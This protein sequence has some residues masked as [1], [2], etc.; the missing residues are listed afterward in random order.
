MRACLCVLSVY[1]GVR[2]GGAGSGRG[3]VAMLALLC[4][5]VLGLGGLDRFGVHRRGRVRHL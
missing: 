5:F 2:T 3:S 1:V 4:L